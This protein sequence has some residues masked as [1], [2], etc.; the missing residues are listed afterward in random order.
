MMTEFDDSL[1]LGV[2]QRW[3][4]RKAL[5]KMLRNMTPPLPGNGPIDWIAAYNNRSDAD[6]SCNSISA[7]GGYIS[8][9]SRCLG[10]TIAAALEGS[11]WM[12]LLAQASSILMLADRLAYFWHGQ[13]DVL[14]PERKG[15]LHM[16]SF[17]RM[18]NSM[19]FAFLL[20]WKEQGIYQGHLTYAA[21]NRNYQLVMGYTEEHKR[22]HVFMLRLFADWEGSGL[23]HDWPPYGYDVPIY[24]G[25]LEHW[26]EPEPEVLRP[27]LLA[28][29]DRHSHEAR[30]D[31]GKTFFDFGDYRLTRTPIEI[32]LVFRLREYLGLAN[33]V[34]DHPLM[35][36]PFDRLPDP[37]PLFE[38][39]EYMQGTLKRV[40]EDWPKFDEATSLEALR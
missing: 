29:C 21:L 5:V 7:S 33:P 28:A 18:T 2:S 6:N 32:L 3:T 39:D 9:G 22:A 10:E 30:F 20:G 23:T 13:Y 1:M 8:R 17:V 24:N 14:F 35:E 4:K 26:R 31:T 19:A 38:P 40:R 25:I 34:L 16:M 36:A 15:K 27:W 11:A 12:P 37:Q